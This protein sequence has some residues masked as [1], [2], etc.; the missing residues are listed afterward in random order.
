MPATT[1]D[2]RH[3]LAWRRV[4]WFVA[5]WLLSVAALALTAYGL[6]RALGLG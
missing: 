3:R 5:I 4:G 1:T 6:R 2:R